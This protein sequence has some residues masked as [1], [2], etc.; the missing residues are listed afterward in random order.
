[1][2]APPQ[3]ALTPAPREARETRW[4]TWAELPSLGLDPGLV[5]GL[6]KARAYWP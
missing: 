2:V 3:A 4:F 1:L 5:R 6:A